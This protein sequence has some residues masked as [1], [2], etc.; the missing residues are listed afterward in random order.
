M[1]SRPPEGR[2]PEL[3]Q[4]RLGHPSRIQL[5][6]RLRRLL[7]VFRLQLNIPGSVARPRRLPLR[8][9]QLSGFRDD[10]GLRF[11]SRE[12]ILALLQLLADLPRGSNLETRDEFPILRDVLT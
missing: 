2:V 10:G 1:V 7:D 3:P 6:L 8:R 11:R 9:D 5:A 12:P 4:T